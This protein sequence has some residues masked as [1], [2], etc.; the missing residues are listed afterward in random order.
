MARN[1]AAVCVAALALC[2]L[3]GCESESDK[4]Y[5][6][7]SAEIDS[8]TRQ[9]NLVLTEIA[10]QRAQIGAN[11]PTPAQAANLSLLVREEDYLRHQI[12]SSQ[13]YLSSVQLQQAAGE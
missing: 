6:R 12:R 4:E 13:D 3:S 9:H 8:L 7:T 10:V 5:R 11:P 2:I 1:V